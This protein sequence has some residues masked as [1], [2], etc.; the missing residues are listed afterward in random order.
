MPRLLPTLAIL[1]AACALLLA[2][3]WVRSFS[4]MDTLYVR[5][6]GDRWGVT[7]SA[8]GLMF[9]AQFNEVYGRSRPASVPLVEWVPGPQGYVMRYTDTKWGGDVEWRALGFG[10]A[11]HHG[12]ATP[13]RQAAR[14]GAWSNVWVLAPDW[15]AITA[16]SLPAVAWR[17]RRRRQRTRGFPVELAAQPTVAEP[18]T[19]GSPVGVHQ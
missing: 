11:T 4:H 1:S 15:A 14:P 8:G 16:L 5:V 3:L 10:V 2:G 19:P 18:Y 13:P 17:W 6:A 12:T 7:S 9:S